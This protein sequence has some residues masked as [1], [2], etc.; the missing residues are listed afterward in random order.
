MAVTASQMG[1][2]PGGFVKCS[3]LEPSSWAIGRIH[4]EIRENIQ[5]D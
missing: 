2:A 1:K 4:H 5:K 3:T